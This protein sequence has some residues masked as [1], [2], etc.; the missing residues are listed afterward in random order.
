MQLMQEAGKNIAKSERKY[1][2][3]FGKLVQLWK[4][5]IEPGS[6]VFMQETNLWSVRS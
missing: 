5:T 4:D 3:D 6:F 1:K 2:T